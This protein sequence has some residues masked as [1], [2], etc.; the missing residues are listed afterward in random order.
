[1][2]RLICDEYE[3][4]KDWRLIDSLKNIKES[5][6]LDV[7][8]KILDR[9]IHIAQ[10]FDDKRKSMLSQ[11][12]LKIFPERREEIHSALQDSYS[13]SMI[14]DE[15]TLKLKKMLEASFSGLFGKS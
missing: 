12:V 2:L 6:T 5:T 4:K 8:K 14:V 3:P 13:L 10:N 11:A 9:T 15:H 7:Q 1:M